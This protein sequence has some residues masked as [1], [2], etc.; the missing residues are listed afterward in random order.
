MRRNAHGLWAAGLTALLLASTTA[1]AGDR[2]DWESHADVETVTVI[3]TNE[4]GSNRE[5]T[6]WLLVLDGDG[7]I[8]TATTRWGGNVERNQDVGLRIGETELAL[9]AEFV[10]D[11]E[12]RD[13]IEAAFRE[14][15]G[16]E[17]WFSGT[18]MRWGKVKIMKL[19]PRPT[20]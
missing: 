3:T 2:I 17:D 6:I 19:L 13:R 4:D 10:T 16:F 7:Y 15:Y 11:Q 14:K 9:R 8:R 18:F 5:T 1:F 12:A 20:E